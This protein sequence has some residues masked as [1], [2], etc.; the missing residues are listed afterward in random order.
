MQLRTSSLRPIGRR[1]GVCRF[2]LA[3]LH[4][5]LLITVGAEGQ[6]LPS[7]TAFAPGL[8]TAGYVVTAIQQSD[9]RVIIGGGFISVNG[10]PHLN[11]ARLN[12][13]GSVDQSW[14]PSIPGQINALAIIDGYLYV[15]GGFQSAGGAFHQNLARISLLG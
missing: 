6:S 14:N 12:L 4:T 11:L 10:Q 2:W 15:G 7:T 8:V 9:G 1:W 3:L 13:D 5:L